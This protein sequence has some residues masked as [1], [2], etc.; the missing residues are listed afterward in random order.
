[1]DKARF[2]DVVDIYKVFINQYPDHALVSEFD[3]YS[4]DAYTAGGFASLIIKEKLGPGTRFRL[5]PCMDEGELSVAFISVETLSEAV[6]PLLEK[7][8]FSDI[9]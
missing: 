4:I 2:Q 5:D 3:L 7:P 9:S 8:K 1:M 6:A